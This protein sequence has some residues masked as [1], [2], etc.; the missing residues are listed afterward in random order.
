[1]FDVPSIGHSQT[2]TLIIVYKIQRAVFLLV[3]LSGLILCRKFNVNSYVLLSGTPI[4]LNDIESSVNLRETQHNNNYKEIDLFISHHTSH[5]LGINI[6]A[7][8]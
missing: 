6:F 8:G 5:L 7:F 1:M 2:L 3:T 4:P